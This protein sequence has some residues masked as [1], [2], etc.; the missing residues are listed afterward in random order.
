MLLGIAIV[1]SYTNR[2]L[3]EN[4][5]NYIDL[6]P[7]NNMGIFLIIILFLFFIIMPAISI[8]LAKNRIF[9]DLNENSFSNNP[10]VNF[11]IFILIL[12]LVV[13]LFLLI[14]DNLSINITLEY[15]SGISVLMSI[16][17]LFNITN[18]LFLRKNDLGQS[19]THPHFI[20]S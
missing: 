17:P 18:Y 15:I 10:I 11:L 12:I 5:S 4:Q 7:T 9:K 14:Q 19:T 3:R 20:N 8:L 6:F 2:I 13:N 16:K 1:Y